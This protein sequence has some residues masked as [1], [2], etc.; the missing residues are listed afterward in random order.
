MVA[1]TF[2]VK[3]VCGC[4]MLSEKCCAFS[5]FYTLPN[6]S[7]RTMHEGNEPLKHQDKAT[8]EVFMAKLMI[9]FNWPSQSPDLN[10]NEKVFYTC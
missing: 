7:F 8:K 5:S 10:P 4:F 6:L 3:D 9:V 1:L 2:I